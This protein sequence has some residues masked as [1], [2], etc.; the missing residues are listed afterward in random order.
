MTHA[1]LCARAA[2]WL[3]GTKG[4]GVVLTEF[5]TSAPE[6][7]DAIGWTLG[8]RWSVLVECKASRADFLRDARKPHRALRGPGQERWFL[9]PPAIANVQEVPE[10]WGLAEVWGRRVR[11][12]LAAPND[13]IIRADVALAEAP[14]LY[15]A[16]R[17]MSAGLGVD[18]LRRKL[19]LADE[20]ADAPAP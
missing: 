13:G 3:A 4:C 15:S 10:G 19:L 7:P 20:D 12:V 9:A 8:A 17:R 14:F 6:V 1:D 2:R 18:V 11:V 16:L 5:S